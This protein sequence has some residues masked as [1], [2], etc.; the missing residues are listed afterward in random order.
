MSGYGRNCSCHT[1]EARVLTTHISPAVSRYRLICSASLRAGVAPV[2]SLEILGTLNT[3]K[4]SA[5]EGGNFSK[6]LPSDK[7]LTR[8]AVMWDSP[9]F[10]SKSLC[11]T[12]GLPN[13]FLVMVGNLHHSLP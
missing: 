11:E 6:T 9:A 10:E 12:A 7:W 3:Q 4:A 5:L 1:G 13:V 8:V 2:K